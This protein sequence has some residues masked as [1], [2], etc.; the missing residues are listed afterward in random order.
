MEYYQTFDTTLNQP[1]STKIDKSIICWVN[2]VTSGWQPVTISIPKGSVL[3]SVLFSVFIND[4]DRGIKC[5][6][7]KFVNDT[8]LR[9]A[10][11]SL[12]GK[13]VLQRDLES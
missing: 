5:T 9:R 10:V 2:G 7:S 4:L 8:K 3:Q 13:D 12:E 11:D 6:I 1:P